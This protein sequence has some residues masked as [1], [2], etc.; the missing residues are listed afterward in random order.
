MVEQGAVVELGANLALCA[1]KLSAD[2]RLP[3]ADS[4]M[5]PSA[6]AHNAVLWRQEADFEGIEGVRFVPAK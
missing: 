2:L 6:S 3:V 4:I 5:L 1:V